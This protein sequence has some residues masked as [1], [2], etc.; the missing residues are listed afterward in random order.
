[1]LSNIKDEKGAIGVV[2]GIGKGFGRREQFHVNVLIHPV[3]NF[4]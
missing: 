2:I 4:V 3:L 1:M